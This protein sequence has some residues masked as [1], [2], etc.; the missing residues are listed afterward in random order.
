MFPEVL[1]YAYLSFLWRGRH[2][3]GT[4]IGKSTSPFSAHVVKL[5]SL[6]SLVTPWRGG[7]GWGINAG[8]TLTRC[9]YGAKPYALGD[10]PG[11]S[12]KVEPR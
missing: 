1:I 4:T 12:S 7:A 5:S 3:A 10:T 2:T 11:C 8:A 9:V 6:Q